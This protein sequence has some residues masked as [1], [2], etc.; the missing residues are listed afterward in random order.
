MGSFQNPTGA[1]NPYLRVGQQLGEAVAVARPDA[2]KA[3][4]RDGCLHWLTSKVRDG[5]NDPGC[6]YVWPLTGPT[7]NAPIVQRTRSN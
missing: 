4:I 5:A 1:L 2:G 7:L 6:S 3:E